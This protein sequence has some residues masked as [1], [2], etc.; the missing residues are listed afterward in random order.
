MS[1]VTQKFSKTKK[2][3]RLNCVETTDYIYYQVCC[4]SWLYDM[5]YRICTICDLYSFSFGSFAAFCPII[6]TFTVDSVEKRI[7]LKEISRGRMIF[8]IP[9]KEGRERQKFPLL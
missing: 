3:V 2:T 4:E 7:C 5:I 8:H 9:K 6:F 1:V